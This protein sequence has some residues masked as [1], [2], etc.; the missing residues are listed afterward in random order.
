MSTKLAR[1]LLT[2]STHAIMAMAATEQVRGRVGV[3]GE[4]ET[5]G[6]IVVRLL[7]LLCYYYDMGRGVDACRFI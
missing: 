2:S 5:C 1:L 7:L 6:R 3:E 4:E